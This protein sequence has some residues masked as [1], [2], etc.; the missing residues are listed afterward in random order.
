MTIFIRRSSIYFS[1]FLSRSSELLTLSW[2]LLTYLS[3]NSIVF[4]RDSAYLSIIAVLVPVVSTLVCNCVTVESNSFFSSSTFLSLSTFSLL[5]SSFRVSLSF[6]YSE[7]D[8]LRACSFYLNDIFSFSSSFF[9]WSMICLNA[10]CSLSAFYLW[11]LLSWSKYWMCSSFYFNLISYFSSTY[12]ILASVSLIFR[13]N[14]SIYSFSLP[15]S[16]WNICLTEVFYFIN[17]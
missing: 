15:L 1:S 2:R 10:L 5:S 12:F 14:D 17:C 13:S 9:W 6:L 8:S 11:S 4:L 3:F 16:V 7:S